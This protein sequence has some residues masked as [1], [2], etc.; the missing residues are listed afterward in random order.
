MFMSL[1]LL[2]WFLNI[3]KSVDI[4]NSTELVNYNNYDIE[5]DT[6]YDMIKKINNGNR[7][8]HDTC[9]MLDEK[10]SIISG[11]TKP[12]CKYNVSYINNSNIIMSEIREDIRTFLQKEKK[13]MCKNEKI[14]CGELTIVIKLLDLTN[15]M[16]K[17]CIETNNLP[18]IIKNIELIEFNELYQVYVLSLNN[19]KVL[20]NITLSKHRANVILNREK[21]K[22]M[23]QLNRN[24]FD[25]FTDLIEV[26]FSE[27]IKNVFLYAGKTVGSTIGIFIGSTIDTLSNSVTLS[28]EQKFLIIFIL[29]F[30]FLNRK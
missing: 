11:S 21:I 27:P 8:I 14:E 10:Y 17:I 7:I 28:N 19:L 22:L 4:S 20:T 15:S 6:I 13:E 5:Y 25:R 2:L 23:K 30:L 26:Y 12:N 29:M 3:T 16:I 24:N 9:E 1:I 18:D